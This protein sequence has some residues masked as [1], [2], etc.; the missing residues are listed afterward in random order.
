MPLWGQF[1]NHRGEVKP[2]MARSFLNAIAGQ[3]SLSGMGVCFPFQALTVE[4]PVQTFYRF[5]GV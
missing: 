4:A 1:L 2:A 5:Y 3:T